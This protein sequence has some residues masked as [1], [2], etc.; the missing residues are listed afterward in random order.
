MTNTL[1]SDVA[2]P[3]EIRGKRAPE[4]AYRQG[5]A[6]GI[7]NGDSDDNPYPRLGRSNFDRRLHHDWEAGWVA[8]WRKRPLV[9]AT[10]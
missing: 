6:V 3:P 5:Y 8:G 4:R 7:E 2:V 9:E 10:P 1:K